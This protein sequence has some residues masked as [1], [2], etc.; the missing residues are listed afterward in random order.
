MSFDGV[1]LFNDTQSANGNLSQ[2]EISAF[3]QLDD[4]TLTTTVATSR[5]GEKMDKVDES[6]DLHQNEQQKMNE[7]LVQE[8]NTGNVYKRKTENET[9]DQPPT[10]YKKK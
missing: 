4:K 6:V 1:Q 5:C 9:K 10:K 3:S 7:G 2:I 8:T